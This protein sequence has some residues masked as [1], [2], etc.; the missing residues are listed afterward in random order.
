MRKIGAKVIGGSIEP[1]VPYTNSSLKAQL[2]V[3]FGRGIG[4][5]L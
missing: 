2:L 5:D 1:F 4:N 3:V